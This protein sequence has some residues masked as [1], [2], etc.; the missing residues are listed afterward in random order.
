M[1][2]LLD[3]LVQWLNLT[4]QHIELARGL[5]TPLKTPTSVTALDPPKTRLGARQASL[6]G[7]FHSVYNDKNDRDDVKQKNSVKWLNSAS[8]AWWWKRCVDA[9]HRGA[10]G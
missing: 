3:S 7:L 10:V 4:V 9:P 5:M 1:R 8:A 2:Y 6:D